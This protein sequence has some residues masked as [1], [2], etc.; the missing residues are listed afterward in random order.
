[1]IVVLLV[2]AGGGYYAYS[3]YNRGHKDLATAKADVGL[4]DVNLIKAFVDNEA[5]ANKQYLDKVIKIEGTVK[6]VEK[7]AQGLYTVYLGAAGSMNSV[8]C[9]MAKAHNEEVASL[10]AGDK[11]VF[12][13]KCAGFLDDVSLTECALQK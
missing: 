10:K 12:Q 13:G 11:A 1:M 5:E 2:L 7:D 3:E 6:S 8:S 4:T 9:Q